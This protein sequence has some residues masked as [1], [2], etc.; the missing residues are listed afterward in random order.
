MKSK[1]QR[2]LEI[3]YD[4]TEPMKSQELAIRLEVSERTIRDEIINYWDIQEDD[5][6]LVLSTHSGY[7]LETKLSK[8]LFEQYIRDLDFLHDSSQSRLNVIQ[9]KLLFSDDYIK[10]EELADKM[11]ISNATMRRLFNQVKK[12]LE[13]YSLKIESK[14]SYGVKIT[15]L[16]KD[17]RLAF[18]H[19]YTSDTH[20]DID[21]MVKQCDMTSEDYYLMVYIVQK[22]LDLFDFEL[23]Q[24]GK[25][26]LVVHLLYAVSR[27]K[28]G[29][30]IEK[31]TE[32]I[33][34]SECEVKIAKKIISM[35]E[36]E[37][38]VY[39][40]DTEIEYVK[41]H[42]LCKRANLGNTEYFV[43]EETEQVVENINQLILKRLKLDFTGDLELLSALSMHF[44]S[45]L[46]RIVLGLKM[47]NPVLLEI[48]AQFPTAY[49][50]AVIAAEYIF[51]HY[52][53]VLKDD[54]L[55]YLAIHYN[56][57]I[58]RLKSKSALKFLIVCSSGMGTAKLLQ[59]K[60]E[61]Q[62]HV[63]KK[64]VKLCS[65]KQ[66]QDMDLTEI[67]Y[68]VSTVKIPFT[69][70]KEIIYLDNVMSNIVIENDKKIDFSGLVQNDLVFIN[71]DFKDKKSVLDFLCNEVIEF[72]GLN[73]DFKKNVFKR[74]NISSTDIGN[75]VA[76]PHAYELCTNESV[77][78]MCSLKKAILWN[79]RKVKYIFL[80]S[81][82]K[83]DLLISHELNEKLLGHLMN[84]KWI[85][86]LDHV[87]NGQDLKR[88][89][90]E[91]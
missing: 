72:Y 47:P 5:Q 88:L 64:D 50:C 87:K 73:Q 84:P 65:L 86:L 49:D 38:N 36:Q 1:M 28:N 40:P 22:S 45:M 71:Q 37:F 24:I 41:I 81:Y 55:G 62:F 15:G 27:I 39:F 51:E 3:L 52:Q 32:N 9:N 43:S 54:E 80:V 74:E 91:E 75:Y 12:N 26:N 85:A 58:E 18:T 25:R 59:N 78:V 57:A 70:D 90:E 42:L 30:Y 35:I 63:Q 6:V 16:E 61:N 48:K 33:D 2:I 31:I 20:L 83:K 67:D 46:S 17:K 11:Y 77:F 82:A 21:K 10:L 13:L 53:L 60:I 66:L 14:P 19:L 44:E 76:I 79:T 7:K 8:G 23:T 89:L 69:L 68:V 34:T 29:N 56:L 4:A